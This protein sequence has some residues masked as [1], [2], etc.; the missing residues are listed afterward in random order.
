MLNNPA[1]D[2]FSFSLIVVNRGEGRS[3]A[4]LMR[5]YLDGATTRASQL[6]I[7]VIEAGESV[8]LTII[9]SGPAR[10]RSMTIKV[11]GG[12]ALSETDETNNT[13]TFAFLS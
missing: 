8:Q 5:L 2:A 7:P 1:G 13:F 3:T 12:D 4:S 10:Q 9:G 6:A 11:D